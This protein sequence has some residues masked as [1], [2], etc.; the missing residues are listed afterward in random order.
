MAPSAIDD[1]RIPIID[2][3]PFLDG[4]KKQEVADK[5][6]TAFR[7]IGFIYLINHG[8]P[9][10]RIAQMFEMVGAPVH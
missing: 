10:E 1:S 5:M 4:T 3:S 8:I 9:Q 7:D 2:F 6:L